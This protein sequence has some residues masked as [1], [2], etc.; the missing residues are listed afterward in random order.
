[1]DQFEVV[2]SGVVIPAEMVRGQSQTAFFRAVDDALPRRLEHELFR[3][4]GIR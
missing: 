1:M 4:L 2:R 3:V